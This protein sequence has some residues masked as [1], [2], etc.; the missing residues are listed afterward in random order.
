[1]TRNGRVEAVRRFNRFY[2]RRIGV[3]QAGLLGS[4]FSLAESRVLYELAH[5]DGAVAAELAADLDVDAGYLS[6]LLRA[7][8]AR[9][10]VARRRSD[11]DGRRARLR[12][13]P[14]GRRAFAALDRQSQAAVGAL[15]DPLAPAG[16]RRLVS[17][18]ETIETLL[19][20]RPPSPEPFVI[21]PPAPGDFGWIV[22]Q[23]G[24]VYAREYGYD[25]TFEALVASVVSRFVERSDSRRER[26]WI[27]EKDGA[28]VGS[29]LLVRKSATVGKLRLLIVDPSARG[30]GI[31]ARLIDEC[32]RFARE[33]GYRTITL[34]THRHLTA[35]RRLY[36]KAGFRLVDRQRNRSFGL[37]LVDETWE[38]STA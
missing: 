18:M 23:H 14:A 9:R 1:M 10:L 36:K 6:R 20:D 26:C 22:Q 16:Q 8:Q 37:D 5:R 30:L 38:R 31:G 35:A 24:T 2:T 12:L 13:T 19:G 7:L 28:P 25:R 32:I 27:A 3:L 33:V 29:V 11:A 34:W 21:R 4:P 15:L 17:A